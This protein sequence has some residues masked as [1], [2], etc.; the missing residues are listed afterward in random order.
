MLDLIA[1]GFALRKKLP[2][3]NPQE[4]RSVSATDTPCLTRGPAISA[5]SA[6]AS[7]EN[8]YTNY[9]IESNANSTADCADPAETQSR[10]EIPVADN[11]RNNCGLETERNKTN[12]VIPLTQLNPNDR[13]QCS[14]LEI[15]ACDNCEHFTP[16]RIGDGAGIGDCYLGLKWTQEFDGRRPLYRYAD[17]HCE[18]FSKLMS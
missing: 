3:V 13:I 1:N 14:S 2:I 12:H 5:E 18:K 4:I 16:D 10:K 17:R 7:N 6:L 8:Q 11:M 9:Y 15:V